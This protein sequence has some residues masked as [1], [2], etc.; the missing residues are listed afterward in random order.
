MSRD[1]EG[2]RRGSG[3]DEEKLK[4]SIYHKMMP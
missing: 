2:E 4:D 1:T 3:D